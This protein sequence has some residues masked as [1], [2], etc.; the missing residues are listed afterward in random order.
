MEEWL[1]ILLSLVG[2][3]FITTVVS[4]VT[5]RNFDNFFK[6]K[7]EEDAKQKCR[8]DRLKELE[9]QKERE[10]RNQD[11]RKIIQEVIEPLKIQFTKEMS[12]VKTEIADVK[13]DTT[14]IKKGTQAGLRHDLCIMADEWLVKGYCPRDV[15]VDFEN[16]YTQYH[17][18]GKNGVMDSTFQ[19][20]LELPDSK[21]P[22]KKTASKKKTI[23][24]ENK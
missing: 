6:K 11:T 15:K 13:Q 10:E 14:I 18:L 20:I 9:L 5:K 1:I 12:G 16:L 3:T 24:N 2:S 7:E 4:L 22:I 8:D 19:A 23:L 21:P 17:N